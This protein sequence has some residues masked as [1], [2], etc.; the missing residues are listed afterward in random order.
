MLI[1]MGKFKIRGRSQ[2]EVAPLFCCLGT[3]ILCSVI[4]SLH[5]ADATKRGL[6]HILARN[7]RCSGLLGVGKSRAAAAGTGSTQ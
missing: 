5:R 4:L 7:C 2:L 3:E 1:G 6:E